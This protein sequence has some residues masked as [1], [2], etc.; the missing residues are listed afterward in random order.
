[1]RESNKHQVYTNALF[2]RITNIYAVVLLIMG[3]LACYLAYS[4]EYS[5]T[6]NQMNQIMT[7][8]NYEYK[9]STENFWRLYM[10]MFENRDNVY[11]AMR[12]FF[13]NEDNSILSPID[14]SYLQNALKILMSSDDRVRWIGIYAGSDSVNYLLFEGDTAMV[15]MPE[16]FPFIEEMENKGYSMEIYGSKLVQCNGKNI[17][18]FA[19]CGGTALDMRGGNI[20]VGYSVDDIDS[21]YT[22]TDAAENVSF[23]IVNDYG[24]VYDSTGTYEYQY[25]TANEISTGI[26]R[27]EDGT[28]VYILK[29]QKSDGSHCVF[30]VVPWVDMLLKNH[31]FTPFIAAVVL[32]F[33]LFSMA[34]YRWAGNVI[35][36]KIDAIQY[37]LQRIGDNHLDYRIS[38]SDKR[39]DE[40][41]NIS[42][43]INEVAKRLQ[44]N[45]DKV[46]LS[47]LKQKEAELAELQAKFDPH[48]LY[49]TLE[50]IRGKVYDNGDEE[51]ADII[52]KLAQIFRSFIGSERFI[53][54]QEEMEFCN[55]YLSL[56]KY[57]YDNGVTIVYDV[58]SEIL[59][60]GIIRNLLQPIL[61]N[62][63]VHGFQDGKQDN[64]LVIRGKLKDDVYIHFVIKDNGM[65]ITDERLAALKDNLDAIEVSAKSS[66]GLKNV[67]RRIKLF[68]GQEC[69]LEIDRNEEGGASIEVWIRKLTCEEHEARM[70]GDKN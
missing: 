35:V 45:I 57:R 18:S 3:F 38:V 12:K 10:P 56:L 68:Y 63:F 69:G 61:E 16:D 47:K 64:R 11:M 31:S 32:I 67:N 43:S 39:A 21:A 51:T 23:Y 40:F 22:K 59:G 5:Q 28:L 2:R 37:G 53:S 25:E 44:E 4:K 70:Y 52:V 27:N 8:I 9:S 17:R 36:G 46:Y 33:W 34:L 49:N 15:E 66:Y 1:M 48:F 6:V 30:C 24:I 20:I 60:Y 62:Y 14:K 41:E 29:L 26:R 50:V 58:E 19:L 55:L 42:Q 7:D 54:I 13:V 65:G